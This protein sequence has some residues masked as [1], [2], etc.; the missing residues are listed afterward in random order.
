[1][2][3]FSA[4]ITWPIKPE[5]DSD[6]NSEI[7]SNLNYSREH[8]WTFD[9]G[10]TLN[11]S[12]SPHIVPE[13]YSNPAFIDPEE[14]FI[15]SLASCHMLFF[16]SIAA[17]QGYCI[18]HYSDKAIGELGINQQGKKAL[19]TITLNPEVNFSNETPINVASIEKL[20]QQAHELCFIA[21]SVNCK[22]EIHIQSK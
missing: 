1:M 5:N 19:T 6:E 2:I 12:S 22:I 3:E 14:S 13:P 10:L 16:L 21:N 7:F 11:A 15:A 4:T 17:K 9:N 8:Q 20:H 18:Y